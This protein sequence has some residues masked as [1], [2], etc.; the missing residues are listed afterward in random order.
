MLRCETV[1]FIAHFSTL[2]EVR[3]I[4]N[5]TSHVAVPASSVSPARSDS[6]DEKK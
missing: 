2:S 4:Y 5:F 1:M 6:A 3:R